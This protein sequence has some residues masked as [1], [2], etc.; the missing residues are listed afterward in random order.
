MSPLKTVSSFLPND[1]V[2]CFWTLSANSRLYTLLFLPCRLMLELHTGRRSK[3]LSA[4]TILPQ[5][6]THADILSAYCLP[7]VETQ[8]GLPRNQWTYLY[9]I[10]LHTLK[11]DCTVKFV[12]PARLW[13]A[14][15]FF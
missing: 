3:G 11:L 4:S 2:F 7:G 8:A 15:E 13:P 9:I 1:L 14:S 12:V 5:R 6:H 10:M